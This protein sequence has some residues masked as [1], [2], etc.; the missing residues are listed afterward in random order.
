[1]I[2]LDGDMYEST[3]TVLENL[4]PN[5]SP[6]GYA[7]V[8]DYH[9]LPHCQRAVTD[10]RAAHGIDDEIHDDRLDRRL[11]AQALGRVGL[12][13]GASAGGLTAPGSLQLGQREQAPVLD[14]TALR[15]QPLRRVELGDSLA[16]LPAAPPADAAS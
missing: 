7:I 12:G 3:I 16:E 1:M 5:L 10:Y 2:R 4:Y 11:L 14:A 6:G 13:R 9:S 15:L 8:D